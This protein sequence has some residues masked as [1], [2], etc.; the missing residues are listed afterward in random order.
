VS[1]VAFHDLAVVVVKLLRNV[2]S[3]QTKV[4]EKMARKHEDEMNTIFDDF[5]FRIEWIEKRMKKI[6]ARVSV[7]VCIDLLDE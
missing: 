3:R 1:F 2:N 6:L 4:L 5:F 7:F